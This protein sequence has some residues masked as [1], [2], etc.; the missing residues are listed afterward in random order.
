MDRQAAK[1]MFAKRVPQLARLLAFN[2]RILA[3]IDPRRLTE[4]C[5]GLGEEFWQA[6]LASDRA[7]SRLSWDLSWLDPAASP[8]VF[9]LP[10]P[11]LRVALLPW[12]D[13]RKALLWFGMAVRFRAIRQ[14][15]D[16]R[17]LRRLYEEAGPGSREFVLGMGSLLVGNRIRDLFPDN[18]EIPIMDRVEWSAAGALA[19]VMQDGDPALAARMAKTMPAA[20][21][22]RLATLPRLHEANCRAVWQALAKIIR[23][24]LPEWASFFS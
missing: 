24:A 3:E 17:Q 14:C 16:G 4:A 20:F 22:R 12:P 1:T 23:E 13:R 18:P 7:V 19:A 9:A 5:G 8:P 2:S 6:I 21:E 15:V 11:R 10:E